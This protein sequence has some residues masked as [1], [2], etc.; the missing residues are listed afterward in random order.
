MHQRMGFYVAPD[1]RLLAM[2]FYGINDGYG[3]GRV[4]REVYKNN[5]FGPIYFIRMND[6]W[7]GEVKYPFY[8]ISLSVAKVFLNGGYPDDLNHKSRWCLGLPLHS[9]IEF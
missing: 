1:G 3:I 8:D 6:N 4:V 7:K 9:N 5:E 2:G